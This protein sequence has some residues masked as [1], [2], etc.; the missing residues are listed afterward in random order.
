VALTQEIHDGPFETYTGHGLWAQYSGQWTYSLAGKTVVRMDLDPNLEL[1]WQRERAGGDV[2]RAIAEGLP[3][4]KLLG[5][6]FRMEMSGF[7]RLPGSLPL[8]GDIGAL[9]PLL[10]AR[11]TRELGIELDFLP[12]PQSTPQGQAMRERIVREV[13]PVSRATMLAAARSLSYGG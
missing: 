4:T 5:V 11:V 1:A 10:A 12:Y 13:Q 8:I 7:C 9:W 6:P 2:S 3:K